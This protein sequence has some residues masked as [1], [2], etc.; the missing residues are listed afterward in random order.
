MMLFHS[1]RRG[2]K[3][4]SMQGSENLRNKKKNSDT[5]NKQRRPSES[6]K[7][8]PEST[9]TSSLNN[10]EHPNPELIRSLHEKLDKKLIFQRDTKYSIRKDKVKY[11]SPV[12]KILKLEKSIETHES[13]HKLFE[14]VSGRLE[15]SHISDESKEYDIVDQKK[16]ER[17]LIKTCKE[18]TFEKFIK[19]VKVLNL[20]DQR[21]NSKKADKILAAVTDHLEILD[22]SK[23]PRIKMKTYESQLN[24]ILL[25][26]MGNIKTLILEGNRI[27]DS[28]LRTMCEALQ[29]N[30]TLLELNIGRNRITDKGAQ[31]LAELVELTPCLKS[32]NISWNQIKYKGAIEIILALKANTTI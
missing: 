11:F 32:L 20:T 10:Y 1:Q 23:N 29:S 5:Q 4:S 21:L 16:Q 24:R 6:V 25:S 18:E 26:R 7:F 19:P 14:E 12:K 9:V 15:E 13:F 3:V 30:Q 2:S 28:A 31:Y 22:L 27:K 17:T 8:I